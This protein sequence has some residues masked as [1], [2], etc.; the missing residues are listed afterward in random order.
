MSSEIC[1]ELTLVGDATPER[2]RL[3]P[4]LG[5]PEMSQP[6]FRPSKD[7]P[8]SAQTSLLPRD[9]PKSEPATK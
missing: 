3:A 8:T 2:T 1:I 5:D 4:E 6:A 9:L 7:W